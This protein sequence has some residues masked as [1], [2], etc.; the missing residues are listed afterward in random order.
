MLALLFCVFYFLYTSMAEKCQCNDIYFEDLCRDARGCY[1]EA[2]SGKCE[3]INCLERTRDD[4]SYFAGNLR[5]FFNITGGY[6]KELSGC[7]EL[8]EIKEVD[9]NE[10]NCSEIECRWDYQQKICVSDADQRL[11]QDYDVQ[12]CVGAIQVVGIKTSECVLNGENADSCI[13]LENCEDITYNHSCNQLYCKWEDNECKTKK[14]S[15]YSIYECPSVNKLS[16]QQCYPSHSGCVEFVCSEFAVE[17]NCQNHPR[18]FWSQHLNS[19]HQQTCDKG[20]Y[21]TQCLSFSYIVDN[22]E[23]RWDGASCHSCYQIALVLYL[24]TYIFY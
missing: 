6:C 10:E 4:C 16:Q 3:E 18:C 13:A 7:E 5:C 19:C 12:F 2:K 23:C 20:T 8:Q 24:I 21:A 22:A 9:S 17:L 14:C 11:C 15:D 1:F